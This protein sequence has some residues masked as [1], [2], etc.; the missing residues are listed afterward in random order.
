MWQVSFRA[1]SDGLIFYN[2]QD[3]AGNGDF[4]AFGLRDR[5]PEFRLNLGA[6]VTTLTD[7]QQ[8]ELGILS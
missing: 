4:I 3:S 6:G 7:T 1:E 5:R 2:G 8:I